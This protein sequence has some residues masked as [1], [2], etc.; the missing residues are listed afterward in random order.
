MFL[1]RER[2]SF[3]IKPNKLLEYSRE[4]KRILGVNEDYYSILLFISSILI[5]TS[6]NLFEYKVERDSYLI[7]LRC[8]CI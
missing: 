2:R 8:K 6:M 3:S 7:L 5:V 1:F 4:Q